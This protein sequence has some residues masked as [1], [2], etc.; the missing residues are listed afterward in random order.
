MNEGSFEATWDHV[1]PG[2]ANQ[3]VTYARKNAR[4]G[5]DAGDL[6]QEAAAW[7]LSNRSDGTPI[8]EWLHQKRVEFDDDTRWER[9]VLKCVRNEWAD[10]MQDVRAQAGGQDRATV[11]WYTKQQV[12]ELLNA[13]YDDDAWLEPPVVDG[14]PSAR[15]DPRTGGNWVASLADISRAVGQLSKPER[16]ILV[17][18]HAWGRPHSWVAEQLECSESAASSKYDRIVSK[19]HDLLGGDRPSPQRPHDVRDP[20]RGRHAVQNSYARRIL[21]RQ[22]E[23]AP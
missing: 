20:W 11:A 8:C 6:R 5:I 1:F 3:A 19:V 13:M 17:W 2:V 10:W 22:Y 9:Y 16:D 12:R 14:A 7:L 18:R 4:W 23:G 21:S 15:S